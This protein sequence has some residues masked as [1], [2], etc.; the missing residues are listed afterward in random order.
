MSIIQ[1]TLLKLIASG[2]ISLV[3]NVG[4]VAPTPFGTSTDN[5]TQKAAVMH[6]ARFL[7]LWMIDKPSVLDKAVDLPRYVTHIPDCI[8]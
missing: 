3:G 4:H 1:Q 6:E 2:A 7:N 8:R 5:G